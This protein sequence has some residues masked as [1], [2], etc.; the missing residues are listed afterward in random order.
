MKVDV[1]DSTPLGAEVIFRAII[2]LTLFI[3]KQKI[4]VRDSR[5]Y[6]KQLK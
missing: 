1:P 5:K 4:Y 6:K 3:K 2:S